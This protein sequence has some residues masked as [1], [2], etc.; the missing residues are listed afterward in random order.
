[1]QRFNYEMDLITRS[2]I[3]SQKC[4]AALHVCFGTS[5]LLPLVINS[6]KHIAY[7]TCATSRGEQMLVCWILGSYA[8]EYEY[9]ISICRDM[10]PSSLMNVNRD[11]GGTFRLHL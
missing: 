1:M 9:D 6:H 2:R 8:G 5:H 4:E 10:T 11:F 3:A 7:R